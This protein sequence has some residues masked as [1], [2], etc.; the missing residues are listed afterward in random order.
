[1]TDEIQGAITSDKVETDNTNFA[2]VK[3]DQTC[4][5]ALVP[6][7]NA[8]RQLTWQVTMEK[9]SVY[10]P[11]EEVGIYAEEVDC[12]YGVQIA[13]DVF[14]RQGVTFEYGGAAHGAA[15]T[16]EP[17]GARVF[18][19]V[20]SEGQ[21]EV[22][23]ADARLD[24]WAERPVQV[25]GDVKGSHVTF[26]RPTV[27]YGCVHAEQTLRA[28]APTVV[29]GDVYSGGMVEAADLFAFSVTAH[30]DVTLGGNVAVV[31]PVVRSETGSVRITDR[32]GI[33]VPEIFEQVSAG[34]DVDAPGLWLFDVDAVWEN[35]L[36]PSDVTDHGDGE[37]A[38]RSW[39]TVNELG[40][41]YYEHVRALF[42]E[43]VR[44]TRRDP[45]EIEE[46]RYGGLGSVGGGDTTIEG[47]VVV[48]EQTKTVEDH[49]VTNV[50]QSTTEVDKSTEVHDESTTV[51]DSVVNRS[52]IGGDGDDEGD[53]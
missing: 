50:D 42:R 39:R 51:E 19:S 18:G 10:N 14:G 40:D 15:D 9:G 53:E 32:V 25:Y 8:F 20:V 29:V 30:D 2:T 1:M 44:A 45:P 23:D 46:F 4:E 6:R 5:E 22:T 34:N 27:V 33:F 43:S 28:N 36:L 52:D 49:D 16:D 26:D 38:D 7:E 37:V 11:P 35:A 48:G 3:A 47:D 24:D 41:D 13:G 31:N 17:L 12:K 21:V